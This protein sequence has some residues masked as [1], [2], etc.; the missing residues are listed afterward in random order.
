MRMRLRPYRQGDG[1]YIVKWVDSQRIHTL[2]C[3]NQIAYPMTEE[4]FETGREAGIAKWGN[5]C[6]T[7]TDQAGT[8][9]GYFQMSIHEADNTAFMGHII[10]DRV[11]R[12]MGYGQEMMELAKQYAF[13]LAGV[14]K[15]RL[16]AFD[17][18]VQAVNCY[19]KCGFVV[20][21]YE[22]DAF[23]YEQEIWGRYTLEA[24]PA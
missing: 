18:N 6:F 19:K 3:A 20:I 9:I 23:C 8:P 2:W 10:V 21:R 4:T 11:C 13:Q 1:A 5:S 17:C 14:S 16:A 7:A 24:C 12:G 15:L 22:A